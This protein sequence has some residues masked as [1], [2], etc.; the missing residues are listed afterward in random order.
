MNRLVALMQV[1]GVSLAAAASSWVAKVNP[2]Q[3][4]AI[5]ASRNWV[6]RSPLMKRVQA[7]QW[8][9]VFE[10]HPVHRYGDGALK[11]LTKLQSLDL[12]RSQVTDA[13]LEHLIRIWSNSKR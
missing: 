13:G 2:R 10:W 5:A 1:L 6:A 4:K 8:R 9:V 11:G 3:A 7:S 12:M